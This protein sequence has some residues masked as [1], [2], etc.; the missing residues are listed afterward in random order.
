MEKKLNSIKIGIEIIPIYTLG[1]RRDII[2]LSDFAYGEWLVFKSNKPIYYINIFD[3]EFFELKKLIES[4]KTTVEE[5]IEKFN[6]QNSDSLSLKQSFFG[7][8][9]YKNTE[10]QNIEIYKFPFSISK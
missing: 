1:G 6:I 4:K 2:K 3:D 8:T 7:I 9:N 10:Y 5:V